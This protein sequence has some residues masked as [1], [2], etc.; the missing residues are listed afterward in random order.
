MS[1]GQFCPSFTTDPLTCVA[2]DGEEETPSNSHA[3]RIH[4]AHTEQSCNCSIHGRPSFLKDIPAQTKKNKIIVQQ[5][6]SSLFSSTFLTTVIYSL[7]VVGCR[8]ATDK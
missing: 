2:V 7:Y 3:V 5:Q 6:P 1:Q 8:A 4:E